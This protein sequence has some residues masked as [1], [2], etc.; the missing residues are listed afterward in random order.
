MLLGSLATP[1]AWPIATSC[2]LRAPARGG[3]EFGMLE[4]V[5]GWRVR[6]DS[7][8][9]AREAHLWGE[10]SRM[11]RCQLYQIARNLPLRAVEAL[12]QIEIRIGL[13]AEREPIDSGRATDSETL[14]VEIGAARV[15]L[16]AAREHPW[17]LFRALALSYCRTRLSWPD[18]AALGAAHAAA[19][20]SGKYDR[21]LGANGQYR[22][23]P[24]LAGPAEYFADAS[25]ALFGTSDYHPFVR[26]QLREIDPE[27]YALV[28]RLWT[29]RICLELKPV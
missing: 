28:A 11:L 6:A 12:R 15:F 2:A 22:R 4:E 17:S 16:D 23:H 5:D 20:A 26:P 18:R 13:F 1:I 21:A 19:A 27:G 9:V 14:A 25:T 3:A 7:L 24:A 8:L 29:R 10:T